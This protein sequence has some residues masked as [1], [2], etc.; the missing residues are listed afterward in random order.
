MWV[1]ENPA[2]FREGVPGQGFRDG[3]ASHRKGKS[4]GSRHLSVPSRRAMQGGTG[5]R[6][7]YSG[8]L[9]DELIATVERVEFRVKH[10][11]EDNELERWYA[12]AHTPAPVEADLAGVA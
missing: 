2:R 4:S 12:S 9:I 3:I 7:M 8:M 5:V 10:A 11:E 1:K 6:A